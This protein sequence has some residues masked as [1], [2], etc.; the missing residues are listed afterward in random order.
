MSNAHPVPEGGGKQTCYPAL[1]PLGLC[2]N[3]SIVFLRVKIKPV[4]EMSI[5]SDS[6]PLQGE[7]SR[8][9]KLMCLSEIKINTPNET[10]KNC[11]LN[12]PVNPHLF[13]PVLLSFY[14][15][16]PHHNVI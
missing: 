12:S 11:K 13:D 9:W 1:A 3:K 16:I 7:W 6:P 10:E 8:Q 4:Y 2:L 14:I 5:S 15:K